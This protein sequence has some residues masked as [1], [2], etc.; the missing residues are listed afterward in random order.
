MKTKLFISTILL[1]AL[2]IT[3]C[4]KEDLIIPSSQENS[5]RFTFP[6]GNNSYDLAIADVYEKFG[7][8]IIYK[9]FRN[10]DFN[11][12]WTSPAIGK[13]G[14]D[15]PES[16]RSAATGFIVNHI[17][18]F[19]KPEI[20]KKVL[21]P[22][23][24]VADSVYQFSVLGTLEYTSAFP[25]VYNGLDFWSFCWNGYAP[26]Q[27]NTTTGAITY[28]TQTR[29]PTTPYYYF[30][31]RGVMLKEVFKTAVNIGNIV[32]PENFSSGLDFTTAVKYASGTE[33]DV[34]YFK[35]RGFP[36]QMTNTLNFNISNLTSITKTSPNQNF[37]DYIHLCMRYT[38]DSIE[39][40]YPIA[41]FPIIHQKY[42]IVV[43]H[44]KEKYG[45][46]LVKIAT[47]PVL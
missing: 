13:M 23:F 16:E 27:K 12:S 42:P 5:E 28:T 33:T 21:P 36:G 15:I 26:W 11:L 34:N 37:I 29:K 20:T 35:K 18:G 4:Y 45:I 7:I 17:F 24:Y 39:V 6:Q 8:K 10:E 25:Y 40:N 43:Q 32:T 30:Y 9:D 38:P 44:M 14:F 47:K 41:K 22:Y 1:T 46:D 19:L 3:S 2:I 31:R